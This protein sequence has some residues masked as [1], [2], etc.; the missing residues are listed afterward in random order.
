MDN[1]IKIDVDT[2]NADRLDSFLGEELEGMSRTAI[3]KLIKSGEITV[4]DSQK[5]ASYILKEG[6]RVVVNIPQEEAINILPEN[7]SLDIV[8]EDEDMAIVNKPQGMVVHPAPGN[9]SN[10][11]V[12]GLLYH[13]GD[14]SM[15]NGIIRAGIVHRLD[16]D[17]S[18]L[19]VV[20]KNEEVHEG[21]VRQFQDRSVLKEYISLVFNDVKEGGTID[22][23]IGR[24]PKDRK[25]MAVVASGKEAITSYEI[26]RRYNKYT[27]LKIGLKTGRTHQIR[28]HMA[29]INHPIVGDPIYSRARNEFNLDKQLLHAHKLGFIHPGKNVYMEF[30]EDVPADFKDIIDRLN[31]RVIR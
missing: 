22:K 5:K 23:P 15:A 4:N 7:I 9:Y 26:I 12:N 28:V 24:N 8:Y 11:L 1:I 20:A 3:Q 17:T 16:K 27:L 6:D 21:L 13:I 30:Q 29:S 18:G 14:L 2:D 10:T 31:K 19:L 25:K